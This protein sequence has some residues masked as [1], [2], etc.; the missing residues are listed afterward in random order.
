MTARD[1]IDTLM[2]AAMVGIDDDA[3]GS[4]PPTG[5]DAIHSL[6]CMGSLEVLDASLAAC[7]DPDPLRRRVGAA[8][9]GQLG[10]A[11]VGFTP[12]FVAE[13]SRGL[14]DLLRAEIAGPGDPG[15][16]NDAC[17]ALGHL[18]DPAAIP[19]VLGLREHPDPDVRF[20]VAFALG[21]RET[22]EAIDGLIALSRDA[23]DDVRDWA[24]F[25]LACL[26]PADGPAVRAALHARLD[27][28]KAEIRYEAME[29]L[30]VRG[31][32]S[33]IPALIRALEEDV[34]SSLLD[35]A[36]ALATPDLC[37]A[38]AAAAVGGLVIQASYGPYDLT[39]VWREAMQR[40]G[41]DAAARQQPD[42]EDREG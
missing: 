35:A 26:N 34:S 7:R 23:D 21:G 15:V 8:V 5:W 38:L 1:E 30:A 20:G 25:G 2:A 31:D 3:S 18:G 33:V 42:R 40:C 19:L 16:L 27:D 36:A 17:I 39:N 9:L 28:G 4:H 32:R 6:R 14:A 41:C 22:Q 13:R 29:G 12:V 10:H 37:E 24:T 11:K